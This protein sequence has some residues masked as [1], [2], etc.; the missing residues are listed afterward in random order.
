MRQVA[1]EV[2]VERVQSPTG[3]CGQLP[4]PLTGDPARPVPGDRTQ[5]VGPQCRLDRR[6]HPRGH[7]ALCPDHERAGRDGG[8]QTDER[9]PV[10]S[11]GE[12]RGQQHGQGGG[13]RHDQS[14]GEHAEQREQG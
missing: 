8:Q 2:G 12:G 6:G 10:Q 7:R 11:P 9:G 5:Q 13:L 3:E 1:G 14:G 4:G